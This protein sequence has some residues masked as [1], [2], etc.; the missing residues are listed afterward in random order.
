MHIPF[1]DAYGYR[2]DHEDLYYLSPWEFTAYWTLEYLKPPSAYRI[3]AKTRWTPAGLLYRD[4][5]K[6]DKQAP[7]PKPGEHYVV[8][9]STNRD[10]YISYPNNDKTQVLRNI[11]VM[12]RCARPHVP[13]PCNTPLPTSSKSEEERARIFS[14]YLRPWVLDGAFARPHVPHLS[15]I[16]IIVT[17]ACAAQE[18]WRSKK[19]ETNKKM[20]L[21]KKQFDEAYVNSTM[22]INYPELDSKGEVLQRCYVKAWKDYRCERVVSKN[23]AKIIRQFAAAHLADSLEAAENDE[24]CTARERAPVDTSWISLAAIQEI[25]KKTTASERS[26]K[27]TKEQHKASKYARQIEAAK[28][29]SDK[30][31]NIS[32][33][34]GAR[35]Q[36]H[37]LKEPPLILLTAKVANTI[38]KPN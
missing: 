21:R 37:Q 22:N 35:R 17:E 12:V 14:V 13:E 16:D 2:G 18:Y 6:E 26:D 32:E 10:W 19:T 7:A 29:I 27:S 11:A 31:W 33:E 8:I 28:S 5:L 24:G 34:P 1:E 30:L 36:F 20:R 38:L 4:I 23:A 9:D 25:L 15:N 3:D